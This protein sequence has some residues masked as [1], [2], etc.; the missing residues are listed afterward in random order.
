MTVRIALAGYGYWGPNLAR[1][2]ANSPDADLAAVFDPVMEKKSVVSARHPETAFLENWSQCLDSDRFD[3]VVIAAPAAAHADLVHQALSAGL[4]VLVEKPLALSA[5][6]AWELVHLA[7]EKDRILMVG[8]TFEFNPAVLRI[9]DLIENGEL[10]DLFYGYS[11][12]LNLGIIRRDVDAWWNLAP[13]DVSIF[14]LLFDGIPER[15]WGRGLSPLNNEVADVAFAV[16]EYPGNRSAHIH[17]SWLD[18]SK[19]RTMTL[20]GSRKMVIFDDMDPEG[21]LKIFDK[22]AVPDTS[23]ERF[24]LYHT[25]LHA[26]DILI[27]SIPA[28]EPLAAECAHFIECVQTRSRPRTDGANGARVVEVLEAV[29]RS[30]TQGGAPITLRD[31]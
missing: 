11:Q 13:H 15:V 12:R 31:R 4:D 23:P 9:R 2:L 8:H 14:N 30:M 20:V 17:V 18:P 29:S 24:G 28:I 27:P 6:E 3:A 10:G 7:K 22:K 25:K 26:G 5:A 16:L 1:N 21:R 19:E